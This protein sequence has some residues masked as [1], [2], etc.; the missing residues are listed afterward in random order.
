MLSYFVKGI[1]GSDGGD[2]TVVA[3]NW[4]SVLRKMVPVK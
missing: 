1:E 4:R 3:F 2:N